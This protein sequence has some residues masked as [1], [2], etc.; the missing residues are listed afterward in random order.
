M[1]MR[2]RAPNFAREEGAF[3]GEWCRGRE[4][5]ERVAI[6]SISSTFNYIT[7]PTGRFLPTFKDGVTP[8][9]YLLGYMIF[10]KYGPLSPHLDGSEWHNYHLFNGITL[11]PLT[12]SDRQLLRSYDHS[13]SPLLRVDSEEFYTTPE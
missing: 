7:T 8:H 4:N 2:V 6:A 3:F 11:P 10:H 1:P 12:D 9:I 13:S 5:L